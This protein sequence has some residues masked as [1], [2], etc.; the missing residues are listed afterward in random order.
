MRITSTMSVSAGKNMTPGPIIRE[1][2]FFPHNTGAQA[3]VK[4]EVKRKAVKEIYIN[5][6]REWLWYIMKLWKVERRWAWCTT[7]RTENQ[8]S[9]GWGQPCRFDTPLALELLLT[10]NSGF[11]SGIR[12]STILRLSDQDCNCTWSAQSMIEQCMLN[13]Q[14]TSTKAILNL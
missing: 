2:F 1:D 3:R 9:D 13:R 7:N 11:I 4:V 14:R 8:E 12:H 5:N 6:F 10:S